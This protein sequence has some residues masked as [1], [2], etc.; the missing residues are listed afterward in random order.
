MPEDDMDE[1]V[2]HHLASHQLFLGD[3]EHLVKI[4]SSYSLYIHFGVQPGGNGQGHATARC[5]HWTAQKC[6]PRI[7]SSLRSAWHSLRVRGFFESQT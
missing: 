1:A 7:V 4:S 2:Q 3:K 5:Q 6:R